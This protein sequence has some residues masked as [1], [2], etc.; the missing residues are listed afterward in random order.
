MVVVVVVERAAPPAPAAWGLSTP[1]CVERALD[2][3]IM[4]GCSNTTG[5]VKPWPPSTLFGSKP[6][7]KLS[8]SASVLPLWLNTCTAKPMSEGSAKSE[9]WLSQADATAPTPA[10]AG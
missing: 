8:A 6:T 5:W 10:E 7:V 3:L 4:M 1:A 9:Y 2:R